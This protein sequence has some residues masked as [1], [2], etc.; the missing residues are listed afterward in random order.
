MGAWGARLYQ[1]DVAEDVRDAYK[2]LIGEGKTGVEATQEI[3]EEFACEASDYEDAPI[4][5]FALADTQWTLG[6]LEERVKQEALR[7]IKAG[8]DLRRW[9]DENPKAAKVRA[10][11]LADLEQKLLLTQPPEK[12]IRIKKPFKCEWNIG[13]VYAYL[14]EGDYSKEKG[15]DGR[16]LLVHKVYDKEFGDDIIPIVRVK[17]TEGEELPKNKSEFDKLDYVQIHPIFENNQRVENRMVYLF[18]LIDESKRTIPKKLLF[19]G[20]FKD[21]SLPQ[22]DYIDKNL[23]GCIWKWFEISMVKRYLHHNKGRK[24]ISLRITEKDAE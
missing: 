10:K 18:K 17:I 16:Y 24:G 7:H 3:L 5:W 13:D 8:D 19:V 11:V 20:N 2:K 4:F 23:W 14:L 6:R 12:K 15:L 21:V 9:Q 1:D 22:D